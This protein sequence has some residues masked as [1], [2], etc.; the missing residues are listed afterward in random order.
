[1][2]KGT[3][4]RELCPDINMCTAIDIKISPTD[5]MLIFILNYFKY[6]TDNCYCQ[7]Y[8]LCLYYI[9]TRAGAS[10]DIFTAVFTHI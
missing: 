2:Q 1:M 7:A 10:T 9:T 4:L 6:I 5:N 8:F 3:A